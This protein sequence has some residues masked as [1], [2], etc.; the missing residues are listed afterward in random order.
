MSNKIFFIWITISII[1][2]SHLPP[3]L[4]AV[5]LNSVFYDFSELEKLN[6]EIIERECELFRINTYFRLENGIQP[7]GRRW[8]MMFYQT[9]NYACTFTGLLIN[10]IY[11]F[12]YYGPG[13][14]SVD[15]QLAAT[16]P[17]FVGKAVY[18]AGLT[19]ETPLQAIEHY[20][21][22]RAGFDA[23]NTYRR[24]LAVNGDLSD[25][26]QKRD[27]L[28]VQA[29]AV[30]PSNEYRLIEQDGVILKDAQQLA[31]EEFSMLYARSVS[32][33]IRTRLYNTLTFI[34]KA[35]ADFGA[36][37]IRII[38]GYNQ[39]RFLSP[40]ASISTTTSGF[41]SA[42]DPWVEM[43]AEKLTYSS[44]YKYMLNKLDSMGDTTLKKLDSDYQVFGRVRQSAG[45]ESR[46]ATLSAKHDD[47]YR[48]FG[49]LTDSFQFLRRKELKSEKHHDIHSLIYHAIY[50]GSKASRGVWLIHVGYRYL[51]GKGHSKHSL[52]LNG[53]AGIDNLA[54]AAYR[55][56]DFIIV[57]TLAITGRKKDKIKNRAN[58]A[59]L[60]SRLE[61]LDMM[62]DDINSC[63]QEVSK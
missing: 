49:G 34:K 52:L 8:R 4:A 2:I 16:T 35:D 23:H 47:I 53:F 10:V 48:G 9:T 14:P 25:L 46:L 19:I 39:N 20:K 15:A 29:K 44:R 3:S 17:R 51:Y 62:E 13:H 42:F 59:M 28:L 43:S 22:K 63:R 27:N 33:S 7:A 1:L 30:L 36:D 58:V 57:D 5:K 50:G 37:L 54:G 41:M 40:V 18:L 31:V 21:E 32:L 24:V 12:Y 61:A 56:V 55:L 45:Q 60:K 11:N 6:D 26:L 38:G